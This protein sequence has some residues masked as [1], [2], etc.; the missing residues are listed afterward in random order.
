MNEQQIRQII[1]EELLNI[2]PQFQIEEIMKI[3]KVSG[4]SFDRDIQILNGKDITVGRGTGTKIGTGT[5]QKLGFYGKLPII[6]TSA[7]AAP[8]GGVTQDAEAR[9]AINFIRQALTALGL[10]A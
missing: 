7:I 5:D 2:I 1:R 4:F 6:Q 10:T 8:T 3:I 9:N